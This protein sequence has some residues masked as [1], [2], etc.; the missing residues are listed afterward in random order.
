MRPS[1]V[2]VEDEPDVLDVIRE[3]LEL[4]GFEAI[5]FNH[6][7]LLDT[8]RAEPDLFLLDIMLPKQSGIEVAEQLRTARYFDT[9]MVAMS[10]SRVMLDLAVATGLFQ[11]TLSKPF[12]LD[13]L[14]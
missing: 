12:D 13:Q 4:E 5:G 7:Y 3:T 2:V 6:P 9:P 10:A 8:L 14:I 1:I 11:A